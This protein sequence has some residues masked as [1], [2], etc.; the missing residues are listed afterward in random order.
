MLFMGIKDATGHC[1]L[2]VITQSGLHSGKNDHDA[3][4]A[5][6]LVKAQQFCTEA[7]GFALGSSGIVE[8]GTQM[9]WLTPIHP[10]QIYDRMQQ[11]Q[12]LL[13]MRTINY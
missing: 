4:L 5:A 1:P 13:C 12:G 3:R 11:R 10:L 6:T 7:T 9:N 8:L 2:T